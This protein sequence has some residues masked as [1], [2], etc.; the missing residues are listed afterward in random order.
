MMLAGF[1][2]KKIYCKSSTVQV[3]YVNGLG[4]S[5]STMGLWTFS[6]AFLFLWEF[7]SVQLFAVKVTKYTAIRD[8][9]CNH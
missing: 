6:G 4:F 8:L 9:T 3:K 5:W 1:F 7:F 2:V